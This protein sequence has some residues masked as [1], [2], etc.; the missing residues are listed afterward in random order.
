MTSTEN[1]ISEPRNLKNVLGEDTPRPPTRLGSI[2][3]VSR[4][5]SLILP[6]ERRV[7]A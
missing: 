5:P 6:E 7:D 2:S 4:V 1:S 3:A